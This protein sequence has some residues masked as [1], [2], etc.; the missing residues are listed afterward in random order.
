VSSSPQIS[1][2]PPE[3]AWKL[4]DKVLLAGKIS[5]ISEE[6]HNE[7]AQAKAVAH[8]EGIR[9][10][11]RAY[12]PSQL[13]V[14]EEKAADAWARRLYDASLEYGKYKVTSP[15]G[16]SYVRCTVTCW[17]P[18]YQPGAGLSQQKCK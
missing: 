13:I 7:I 5:E 4:I 18:F 3:E 16:H 15:V 12:Y 11:N 1:S 14:L 8:G 10:R 9:K 6:M 2:P 17:L